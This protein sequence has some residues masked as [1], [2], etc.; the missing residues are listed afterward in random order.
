MHSSQQD[1]AQL[2]INNALTLILQR[3]KNVRDRIEQLE[4]S[5]TQVSAFLTNNKFFKLSL[6]SLI[7]KLIS[8][9]RY[10]Q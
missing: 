7:T 2:D 4:L 9:K 3:S 5:A 6:A 10:F 8:S 1:F